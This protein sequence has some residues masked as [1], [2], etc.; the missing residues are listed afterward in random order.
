MSRRSDNDRVGPDLHE[1]AGRYLASANTSD[2]RKGHDLAVLRRLAAGLWAGRFAV[3]ACGS[4]PGRELVLLCRMGATGLIWSGERAVRHDD[5]A[6]AMLVPHTYPLA[7]PQVRFVQVV[8][9][10]PH[11]VHREHLPALG[12]L[13][14]ELQAYLRQGHDGVC[15]YLRSAQWSPD[16]SCN[17]ALVVWQVSRILTGKARHGEVNSLNPAAR[18]EML[19]LAE[20]KKLP[21]GD[22]LA[23]PHEEDAAEEGETPE[24]EP[25]FAFAEGEDIEWVDPG[26]PEGGLEGP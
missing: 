9:F 4:G 25:A 22:P 17:L 3:P 24:A 13:S 19:R 10:N 1:V 14:A 7:M 26:A 16:T 5:F 21:L 15:C 18:D 20:E 8:P 6:F 2:Q 11:V 23:Y 12:H